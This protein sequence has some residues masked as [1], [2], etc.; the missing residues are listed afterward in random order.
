MDNDSIRKFIDDYPGYLRVNKETLAVKIDYIVISEILLMAYRSN[1][2]GSNINENNTN[3]KKISLLSKLF[4]SMARRMLEK[5]GLAFTCSMERLQS[6]LLFILKKELYIKNEV[7]NIND[8]DNNE[9]E[10]TGDEIQQL[11]ANFLSNSITLNKGIPMWNKN[12]TNTIDNCESSHIDGIN[13][14]ASLLTYDDI[15][16]LKEEWENIIRKSQ[17]SLLPAPPLH[18][19]L[20]TETKFSNWL[21]SRRYNK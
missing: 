12:N 6:R 14:L 5:S 21:S 18:S 7:N 15:L 1:L 17:L 13:F 9:E 4:K 10:E 16:L 19:F 20:Y 11:Y 8:D 2:L 3:D